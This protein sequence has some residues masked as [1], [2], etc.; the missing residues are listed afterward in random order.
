MPMTART[1]AVLISLR[2]IQAAS[3][4][5]DNPSRLTPNPIYQ[6]CACFVNYVPLLWMM[7]RLHGSLVHYVLNARFL[8]Y[9]DYAKYVGHV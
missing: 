5:L 6:L 7:V 4:I 8:N 3:V 9:V 1:S 2:Q